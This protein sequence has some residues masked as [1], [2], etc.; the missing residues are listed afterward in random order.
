MILA[1]LLTYAA[2]PIELLCLLCHFASCSGNLE[3]HSQ[4]LW[5]ALM[6]L[7]AFQVAVLHLNAPPAPAQAFVMRLFCLISLMYFV[8]AI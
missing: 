3:A 5:G 4:H 7:R 6:F 8:G 1:S 2:L